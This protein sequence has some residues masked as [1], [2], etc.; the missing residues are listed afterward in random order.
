MQ[1]YRPGTLRPL[2]FDSRTLLIVAE[3]C[4]AV[5]ARSFTDQ[6]LARRSISIDGD[7]PGTSA[8]VRGGDLVYAYHL[9]R[10]LRC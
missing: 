2:A 3:A 4:E 5:N 7:V 1:V 6:R 9:Q 10:L 8:G